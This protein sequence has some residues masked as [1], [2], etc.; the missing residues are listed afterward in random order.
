MGAQYSLVGV[1][2]V[3]ASIVQANLYGVHTYVNMC[4]CACSGP[5]YVRTHGTI[6]RKQLQVIKLCDM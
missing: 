5:H 3:C 1:A 2:I 6:L 4:A